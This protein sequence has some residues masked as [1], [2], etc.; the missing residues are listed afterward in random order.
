MK[1]R[2]FITLLGGAVSLFLYL[3]AAAQEGYYG[4]GHDRWHMEFYLK[5]DRNDGKGT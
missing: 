4:E 1:R 3:S 5:L 2:A